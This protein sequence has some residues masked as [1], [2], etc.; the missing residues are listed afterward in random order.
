M[1]PAIVFI[2]FVIAVAH[3]IGMVFFIW[4]IDRFH[5]EPLRYLFGSFLRGAFGAFILS[6]IGFELSLEIFS[7]LSS[8]REIAIGTTVVAPIV[9]EAMKGLV[10]FFLLRYR[11]FDNV[12]DGLV[13]G[14]AAGLWYDRKFLL[15][16][17][18]CQTAAHRGMAEPALY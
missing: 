18:I 7:E 15:F 1:F 10:I 14:A 6:V 11:D 3:M 17:R 8:E 12:T 13:Y 16:Y 9:E 4:W 5:R 2:S